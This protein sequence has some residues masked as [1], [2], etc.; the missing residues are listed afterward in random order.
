MWQISLKGADEAQTREFLAKG[1]IDPLFSLIYTAEGWREILI[2]AL[3]SYSHV[4]SYSWLKA[5]I[6]LLYMMKWGE[7]KIK[8]NEAKQVWI[9]NGNSLGLK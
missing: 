8:N 1:I 3:F 4:T 2:K 7:K 5:F 9:R 6:L